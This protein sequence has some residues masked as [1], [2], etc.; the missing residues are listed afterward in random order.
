MDYYNYII[1]IEVYNEGS[2]YSYTGTIETGTGPVWDLSDFE[3]EYAEW[4][5]PGQYGAVVGRWYEPDADLVY[6]EPVEEATIYVWP[7]EPEPIKDANRNTVYVGNWL[8]DTDGCVEV[9]SIDY[10]DREPVEVRPVNFD[11]E[12][13]ERYELD[14]GSFRLTRKE[15]KRMHR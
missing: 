8:W 5:K 12:D 6:D 3:D 13:P 10:D 4:L 7:N 15:V 9:V 2:G 11:D 1:E 14:E